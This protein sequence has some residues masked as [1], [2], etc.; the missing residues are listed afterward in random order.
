LQGSAASA[1]FALGAPVVGM[2]ID[3][4]APAGGFAAA[5][6]AGLAAALTGYLLSRRSPVA[7]TRPPVPDAGRAGR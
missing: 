5:G 1:G 2:A 3:A 7:A 4:S 6:L